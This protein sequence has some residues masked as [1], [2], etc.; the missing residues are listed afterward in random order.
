MKVKAN[1]ESRGIMGRGTKEEVD[2]WN[3]IGFTA[4]MA[5]IAATIF[6]LG[7]AEAVAPTA[8]I[9]TGVGIAFLTAV[10]MKS[11]KTQLN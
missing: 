2:K 4:T 7:F 1:Q 11:R 6:G 9:G 3:V 10:E 8:L 5:S